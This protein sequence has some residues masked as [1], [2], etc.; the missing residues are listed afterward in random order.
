MIYFE[1]KKINVRIKKKPSNQS[2]CKR[3]DFSDLS[4]YRSPKS[5]REILKSFY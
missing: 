3:L 2:I 4:K 5:P 1:G